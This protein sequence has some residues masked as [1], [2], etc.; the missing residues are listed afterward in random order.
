MPDARLNQKNF[1]LW[2]QRIAAAEAWFAKKLKETDEIVDFYS[3]PTQWTDELLT[4][5]AVEPLRAFTANMVWGNIDI[6]LPTIYAGIPRALVHPRD[7]NEEET[8]RS[9]EKWYRW[10]LGQMRWVEER[11]RTIRTAMLRGYGVMKLA[12]RDAEGANVEP[13]DGNEYLPESQPFAYYMANH[14]FVCDPDCD[15]NLDEAGWIAFRHRRTIEAIKADERYDADVRDDVQADA[16]SESFKE[17]ASKHDTD[18]NELPD[19]QPADVWEVWVRDFAGMKRKWFTFTAS[20]DRPLRKA[21]PW[22]IK[23]LDRFPADVLI[24]HPREAKDAHSFGLPIP[25][26]RSWMPIQRAINIVFSKAV[27]GV[28]RN[29]RII[30]IDAGKFASDEEINK[31]RTGGDLTLVKVQNARPNEVLFPLVFGSNLQ[32][33]LPLLGQL[34]VFWTLITGIGDIQRG[35]A[36]ITMAATVGAL[37]QQN[38]SVRANDRRQKIAESDRRIMRGMRQIAV[39]VMPPEFVIRVAGPKG[40][41]WPT[42][43]RDELGLDLAVEIDV[44]SISPETVAIR[45]ARWDWALQTI[46]PILNSANGVPAGLRELLRKEMVDRGFEDAELYL[47]PLSTAGPEAEHAA[48]MLDESPPPQVTPADDDIAHLASHEPWRERNAQR[49]AAHVI[50]QSEQGPITALH[51]VDD[52]I[53]RHKAQMAQKRGSGAMSVRGSLRPMAPASG[54]PGAMTGSPMSPESVGAATN[55]PA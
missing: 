8:A 4:A 12:W 50:A 47:P 7:E 49:F 48:W 2:K 40:S 42:M 13:T 24:F 20:G 39:E 33:I 51:V 53:A 36:P 46:G 30:G 23:G 11:R 17:W 25:E 1:R 26:C 21:A 19:Q 14:D 3:A 35:A 54:T 9:Q 18:L 16:S 41:E 37:Q 29:D 22:P 10:L 34:Q 5:N 15:L 28:S 32:E 6:L 52:H 55:L 31:I 38:A 44:D 43:G 27:N 45:L